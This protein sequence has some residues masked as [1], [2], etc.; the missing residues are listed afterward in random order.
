MILLNKLRD[1]SQCRSPSFYYKL[2]VNLLS[3]HIN[4]VGRCYVSELTI[5]I[6][7]NSKAVLLA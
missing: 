4:N 2:Y 5:N 7:L 1:C 6:C 3:S